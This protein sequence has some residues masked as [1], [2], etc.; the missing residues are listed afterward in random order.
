[1]PTTGISPSLRVPC[2]PARSSVVAHPHHVTDGHRAGS[3]GLS[4]EVT[5]VDSPKHRNLIGAVACGRPSSTREPLCDDARFATARY[6]ARRR[7]D[8][9]RLGL[10]R[11]LCVD[12][13]RGVTSIIAVTGGPLGGC[14]A[15]S[16]S[17]IR[18]QVTVTKGTRAAA[19]GWCIVNVII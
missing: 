15:S 13:M 18:M 2:A 16:T 6:R 3:C 12:S 4:A 10:P 9:R 7:P 19:D 8:A 1:M 11:Y 5:F 17:S 14:R